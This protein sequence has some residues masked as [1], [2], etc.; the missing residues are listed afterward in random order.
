MPVV[1]AAVTA[2]VTEPA[3]APKVTKPKVTK[4]KAEPKAAEPK[5][6]ATTVPKKTSKAVPAAAAPKAVKAPKAK[7][8]DKPVK[9]TVR[10]RGLKA[11]LAGEMTASEVQVAI[12]LS[13]SLKLTLDKEV[14]A[15]VLT[16]VPPKGDITV[17]Q[18]KLTA[19][20]KK[21]AEK[22]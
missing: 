15:G 10:M 7:A 2:A 19:A 18:Y 16:I 11:L 9:M 14:E 6:E 21:V 3:A 12:E 5:A 13:H 4:P 17:A 1:P 22:L 20:G 8:E